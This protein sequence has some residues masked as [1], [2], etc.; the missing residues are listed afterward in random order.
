MHEALE[1]GNEVMFREMSL[2]RIEAIVMPD[3][4]PSMKLLESL[5]F[6]QE[7]LMREKIYLNGCWQDHYLYAKINHDEQVFV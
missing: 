7:G 1:L 5:G 3:N 4:T 6:E 2:H